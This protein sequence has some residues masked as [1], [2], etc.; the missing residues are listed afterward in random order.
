MTVITSLM[1]AQIQ[2]QN[3]P[4]TFRSRIIS[5][6]FNNGKFIT[7]GT[8]SDAHNESLTALVASKY[9]EGDMNQILESFGKTLHD[10]AFIALIIGC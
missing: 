1:A 7:F 6:G 8:M 5:S 10:Q 4:E 9:P 3:L 2:N